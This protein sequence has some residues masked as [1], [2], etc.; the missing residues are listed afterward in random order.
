LVHGEFNSGCG[1]SGYQ[2]Q[3]WND[4]TTMATANLVTVTAG[5]TT[6]GITASLQK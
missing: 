4:K 5:T 6:A 2:T 1:A 3:W